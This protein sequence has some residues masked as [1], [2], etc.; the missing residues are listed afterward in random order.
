MNSQDI[1]FTKYWCEWTNLWSYGFV[2]VLPICGRLVLL[3]R[4]RV[5]MIHQVIG[6]VTV[7]DWPMVDTLKWIQTSGALYIRGHDNITIL[8]YCS[9][10]VCKLGKQIQVCTT[11]TGDSFARRCD[12]WTCRTLCGRRKLVEDIHDLIQYF[13]HCRIHVCLFSYPLHHFKRLTKFFSPWCPKQTASELRDYLSNPLSETELSAHS[14]WYFVSHTPYTCLFVP[15][16]FTV[17]SAPFN[18]AGQSSTKETTHED[19]S[20]GNRSITMNSCG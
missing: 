3:A 2:S 4:D 15:L 12:G 16:E 9:V 10:R 11:L 18:H 8:L 7:F 20:R 19:E 17:S 1:I 14:I 13:D 5:G 6:P